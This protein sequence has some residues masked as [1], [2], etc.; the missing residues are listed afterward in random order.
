MINKTNDQEISFRINYLQDKRPGEIKLARGRSKKYMN[1]HILHKIEL[2]RQ[3]IQ[4]KRKYLSQWVFQ[5]A[6]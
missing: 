5:I 1:M 6:T 2:M 3:T 4:H